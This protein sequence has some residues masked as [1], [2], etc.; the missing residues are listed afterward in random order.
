MTAVKFYSYAITA[1][2]SARS[3]LNFAE[4]GL[5]VLLCAAPRHRPPDGSKR[6]AGRA[7]G[8]SWT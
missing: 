7:T 3:R 8:G 4:I 6:A 2:M 1:M 5:T